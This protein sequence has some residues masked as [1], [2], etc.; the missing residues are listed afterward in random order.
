M[1]SKLT[2]AG[3]TARL[4]F[5]VLLLMVFQVNVNVS[6]QVV[7][8]FNVI[9]PASNCNPA[10]YSFVNTSTG[11]GL[12]YQWNFGVYPGVNSVLQIPVPPTSIAEHTRLNS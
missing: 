10:V 5:W 9:Q 3:M 12:T 8:G 6:A 2:N 7:A 1:A 4:Q 11:A